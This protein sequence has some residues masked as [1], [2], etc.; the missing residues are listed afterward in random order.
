[1]VQKK[2]YRA[3]YEKNTGVLQHG[4]Q[5]KANVP[6]LVNLA[7]EVRVLSLLL[8]VLRLVPRPPSYLFIL[9][10]CTMRKDFTLGHFAAIY[11]SETKPLL[12]N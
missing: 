1:M 10:E 3:I 2:Y 8:E 4:I 5:R 7:M 11:C 6:R 9:D 12:S